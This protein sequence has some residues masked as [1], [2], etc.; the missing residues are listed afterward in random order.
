MLNYA[1]YHDLI[2]RPVKIWPNGMA[3][4][5]LGTHTKPPVVACINGSC[6]WVLADEGR[7]PAVLHQYPALPAVA[8]VAL[9][10]VVQGQYASLSQPPQ[11]GNGREHGGQGQG[12]VEGDEIE[13]G[14]RGFP[15]LDVEFSVFGLMKGLFPAVDDLAIESLIAR[16]TASLPT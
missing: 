4:H 10:R 3:V 8:A 7:M 6:G 2:S 1:V 11:P 12:R 15:P 16:A 14:G 13:G 9:H 5:N